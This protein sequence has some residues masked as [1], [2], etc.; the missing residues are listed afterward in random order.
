MHWRGNQKV[1]PW[2]GGSI[3]RYIY[4]ESN[5]ERHA[6]C[7]F[8]CACPFPG[9]NLQYGNKVRLGQMHTHT[10]TR[11]TKTPR[12]NRQI[13][14]QQR[15]IQ[16]ATSRT[17]KRI[18]T[19]L[20]NKDNQQNTREHPQKSKH[21]ENTTKNTRA[22]FPEP[23]QHEYLLFCGLLEICFFLEAFWFSLNCLVLLGLKMLPLGVWPLKLDARDESH[24]TGYL[25]CPVGC[26]RFPHFFWRRA[27]IETPPTQK[28]GWLFF[29]HGH[30]AVEFRSNVS[31]LSKNHGS[32]QGWQ[33]SILHRP[34]V[35]HFLDCGKRVA[36]SGILI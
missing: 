2:G 32:G 6:G 24:G 17:P 8:L 3:Y 23:F 10:H 27:P 22:M 26:F 14:Q 25:R 1:G 15:E 12:E 21:L 29:P 5:E 28:H 33:T 20:E 34:L 16:P 13:K 31:P 19:H 7:F 9:E 35:L 18:S 36:G 4:I 11:R 30:W